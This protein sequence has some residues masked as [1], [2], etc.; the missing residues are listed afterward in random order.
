MEFK[1]VKL[2][3]F[4]IQAFISVQRRHGES[5]IWTTVYIFVRKSVLNFLRNA[6]KAKY[7]AKS[8]PWLQKKV[9]KKYG[10]FL[11]KLGLEKKAENV[12]H[13]HGGGHG[14]G[15]RQIT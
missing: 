6:K 4:V 2:D 11:N 5:D 15:H 10:E 14:H 3:F 7:D 12:T 13:C 9:N 8:L 1:A